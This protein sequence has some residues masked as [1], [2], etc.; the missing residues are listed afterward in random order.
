MTGKKNTFQETSTTKWIKKKK[1]CTEYV[2]PRDGLGQ[3]QI[4]EEYWVRA[5]I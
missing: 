1:S 4:Q 5:S 2:I 3:E